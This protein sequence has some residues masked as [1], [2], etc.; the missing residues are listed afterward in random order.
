MREYGDNVVYIHRP[1]VFDVL[2]EVAGVPGL[3]PPPT[4]E[5]HVWT[6]YLLDQ[7]DKARDDGRHTAA[8]RFLNAAWEAYFRGK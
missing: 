3:G 1:P 6:N 5:T 2:K 8:Q 4:T 7:H